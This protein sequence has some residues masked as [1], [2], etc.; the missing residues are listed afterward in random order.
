MRV[1]RQTTPKADRR[2][3]RLVRANRTLPATLLR[4]FWDERGRLGQIL[5]A[6]TV[7]S[8]IRETAL[9]DEEEAATFPCARG[10]QGAVGDAASALA[11]AAVEESRLHRRE[12]LQ[13]P[14]ATDV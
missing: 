5:S 7:R 8:R 11:L 12:P 10:R 14:A 9:E 1:C 2:L 6:Q 13:S 3:L 4:L